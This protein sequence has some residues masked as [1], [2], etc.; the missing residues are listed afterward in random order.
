MLQMKRLTYLVAIVA[1]AF[2]F[3]GVVT[4]CC[5]V[6]PTDKRIDQLAQA[7]IENKP[8]PEPVSFWFAT[9]TGDREITIDDKKEVATLAKI[10]RSSG[11]RIKIDKRF[12]MAVRFPD[13]RN[14]HYTVYSSK[15]ENLGFLVTY[16]SN[17]GTGDPRVATVDIDPSNLPASLAKKLR[18][19][20]LL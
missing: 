19:F 15:G 18:A 13:G 3:L 8:T 2:F 10:F 5:D 20:G 4:F 16:P 14:I 11:H 12:Q 17:D 1:F 7:F 9:L 6:E